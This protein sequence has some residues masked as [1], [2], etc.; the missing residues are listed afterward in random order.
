MCWFRMEGGLGE[1]EGLP[2]LGLRVLSVSPLHGKAAEG[3]R[4][5]AF[6]HR[7]LAKGRV[8]QQ[9][10]VLMVSKN[11]NKTKKEAACVNPAQISYLYFL[12]QCGEIS[13]VV[14]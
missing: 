5:A 9:D 1:G 2:V 12:H 14:K 7:K 11:R 3:P 6:R 13:V 10:L 8:S 4:R